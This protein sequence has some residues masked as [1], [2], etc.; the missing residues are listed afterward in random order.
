MGTVSANPII[1]KWAREASNYSLEDIAGKMGQETSAIQAWESGQR[2]PTYIQLEKLAHDYYKR[3]I[4][5]F[6][7][8]EIPKIE[9][10]RQQ[11][12]TLPGSEYDRI[13]PKVL[14]LVRRAQTMIINLQELS[15]GAN[16]SE[17]HILR[18][19][20]ALKDHSVT[21]SAA[22][23]LSRTLI[24]I[25]LEEQLRW[26]DADGAVEKWRDAL[27]DCGVFVFK[28][29][30]HDK[31]ISGF[32]LYDPEFPVIYVNNTM[33]K[34]RQVFTLFHELAH[35]LFQTG[36]IAKII[37]DHIPQLSDGDRHVEVFCNAFAAQFLVPDTDFDPL[38]TSRSLQEI[39]VP[40]LADR[41][42]VSREV[43][44]RKLLDRGIVAQEY[45]EERAKE[46]NEEAGDQGEG[47]GNYYNTTVKYL[48][49]RY[50]DLAFAKYYRNQITIYDLSGYLGVKVDYIPRLEAAWLR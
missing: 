23:T 22:A 43:I 20:P 21:V 4:A 8:P 37:D 49:D 31:S 36:G 11:F 16:P 42:S 44:L 24:G 26:A 15:D 7:F 28:D 34:T 27:G 19:L 45:Y 29:A 6:F 30:F 12:R 13:S 50:L 40:Q 17:R 9:S 35:L 1:L 25:S 2:S 18:E 14:L 10:P 5:L 39:S 46:W 38:I 48:G 41:Y 32:C 47:R 3:P 33:P